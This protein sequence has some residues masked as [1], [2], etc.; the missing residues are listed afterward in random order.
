[1]SK[2]GQRIN[3]KESIM[4]AITV[5]FDS[6]NRK[7][8]EPYGCDFTI[9]PNFKRL[10]EHSVRFENFYAGSLPC[11]PA[12]R[13]LHTGRYNFLHRTWGP[14]EPFDQSA[15]QILSQK[16]V[17]THFISDHAHYWQEGGLTYHNRYSTYD[18]IRGQ[19]G[20][21]W[22]GEVCG[23][24]GNLDFRRQDKVN[25]KYMADEQQHTLV[26]AFNAAKEF[27]VNN[28]SQDN[29]YL[30]I[31]HFDPHEPFFAPERFKELYA[32]MSADDFDWPPYS[33][34][35]DN[36]AERILAARANYCAL[37]TM[38]DEYLG[39]LLDIMDEENMWENTMLIVNTDHGYLLGEHGFFAKNYMPVYNE[40]AHIPFFI[41]DPVSKRKGETAK[42]LAQTI[43]IAP[44]LLDFFGVEK[45]SHMQGESLLKVI[46]NNE[47]IHDCVLFGNFGK[48]VNITDGRHVYMK[49]TENTDRQ[50]YNYTIMPTHIFTPFSIEELI[51]ADRALYNGFKFTQGVA[52]MRVPTDSETAPGN[53]C[54]QYDLHIKYGDLLFDLENDPGQDNPID[55]PEIKALL[56][57][58]M[59]SLMK[60][61]ETPPEQFKRLGLEVL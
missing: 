8:L 17:Y 5:M 61:S 24:T 36:A 48:H 32:H 37:L 19:E 43:D 22:K 27:I 9:T 46:R 30:H 6:L 59:I 34:T 52:V 39:R 26:R 3:P 13:E 21:L 15:P 38:C 53:S 12:R 14:L 49:C 60:E 57:Q 56:T 25:R 50:L 54:Y 1:M 23:F 2:T 41:W 42:Q 4:R 35:G 31:E 10:A 28:A 55:N 11:M 45:G 33:E 51:R 47:N 20:D 16:G 18:F 58:K 7:Y 29:W 44:T 40:I